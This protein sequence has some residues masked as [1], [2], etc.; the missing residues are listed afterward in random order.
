MLDRLIKKGVDMGFGHSWSFKKKLDD[1]VWNQLK[2]DVV[3]LAEALPIHI[4][5]SEEATRK[6][7]DAK[8]LK[9]YD[10]N[11]KL[12]RDMLSAKGGPIRP[13]FPNASYEGVWEDEPDVRSIAFG[14][15]SPVDRFDVYLTN[16]AGSY[17]VK[18]GANPHDFVLCALLCRIELLKPGVLRL[19]STDGEDGYFEECAQW[20]SK[21]LGVELTLPRGVPGYRAYN[22]AVTARNE[23]AIMEESIPKAPLTKRKNSI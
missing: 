14:D 4:R 11:I 10:R 17:W 22:A 20:A 18:T 13:K 23:A 5:D 15:G 1:T 8:E 2:K 16:K 21:V 12:S 19:E 7:M 6:L 9:S 3:F